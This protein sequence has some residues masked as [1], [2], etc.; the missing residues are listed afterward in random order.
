[1]TTYVDDDLIS[2]RIKWKNVDRIEV[3]YYDVSD[4]APAW[5]F[6]IDRCSITNAKNKELWLEASEVAKV[7]GMPPLLPPLIWK[8]Y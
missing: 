4:I 7:K 8:S 5:K 6:W 1:M 2:S 3:F